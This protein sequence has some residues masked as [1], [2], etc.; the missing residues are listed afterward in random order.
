MRFATQESVEPTIQRIARYRDRFSTWALVITFVAAICA[1]WTR[2]PALSV[3]IPLVGGAQIGLNVGYVLSLSIPIISISMIWLLTPL[4]QARRLQE[5]LIQAAE[6][7]SIFLSEVQRQEIFGPSYVTPKPKET[8]FASGVFTFTSTKIRSFIIFVLPVIALGFVGKSY[9]FDLHAYHRENTVSYF[10]EKV[11]AASE[12]SNGEW[13]VQ[14]D[15]FID[16]NI[17]IDED[18][19]IFD[20]TFVDLKRISAFEYFFSRRPEDTN[21]FALAK[22]EL[23]QACVQTRVADYLRRHT[24]LGDLDGGARLIA[25]ERLRAFI[26]LMDE[27]VGEKACVFD[28]FPRFELYINSAANLFG[29]F[30]AI[31]STIFGVKLYSAKDLMVRLGEC[32]T[33]G[34]KTPPEIAA[35]NGAH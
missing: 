17:G 32:E 16:G 28:A 12:Y 9:F 33:E 3:D 11:I 1:I 7:G 31:L 35:N 24:M 34:S 4:I 27:N 5:G 13:I 30:L 6:D 23:Q 22:P 26:R 15:E 2:A 10:T 29:L 18:R 14:D 19:I 8:I 20:W 21:R 25:N